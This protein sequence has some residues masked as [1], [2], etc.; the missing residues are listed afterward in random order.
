MPSE[1]ILII[2]G[3]PAGLEAARGVADL[4]Y[5][6]ILVEKRDRLGGTP[7][8]ANYAALTHGMRDASEVMAEMVV[9]VSGTA[10]EGPWSVSVGV[11]PGTG[12]PRA[13]TRT[14]L[15]VK[16]APAIAS[17]GSRNTTAV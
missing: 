5:Q 14:M 2:G 11:R 3:G 6:A 7:D 8:S 12:S 4:G 15:S 17:A 1:S 16:D 10:L 9:A 13:S